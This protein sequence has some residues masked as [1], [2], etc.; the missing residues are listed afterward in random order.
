M[1]A[2]LTMVPGPTTT[3]R[4]TGAL[5]LQSAAR[6]AR[7]LQDVDRASCRR[8]AIDLSGVTFADCSGL[9]VLI[10]ARRQFN[11]SGTQLRVGPVSPAVQRI[12]ALARV[13][14]ILDP[15]VAA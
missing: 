3:I 2:S 4:V 5:D 7:A 9:S 14:G 15:L 8:L 6:L 10:A 11:G 12:V 13:E 1:T